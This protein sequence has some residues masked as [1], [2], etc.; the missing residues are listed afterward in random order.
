MAIGG[1][2]LLAQTFLRS[3]AEAGISASEAFRQ[4]EAGGI[5]TY[6]RTD[7]LADYREFA[8]I[9]AK[10][11]RL[12]YVRND[13]TPSRDL[14]TEVSGFQRSLY[15]YQINFDVLKRSTG[16]SFTMSTNVASETPLSKGEAQANGVN[17]IK[18][19]LDLSDMDITGYSLFGAFHK[20]G[21]LWD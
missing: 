3:A 21:E 8:N 2:K 18:D 7:M 4:M 16:E 19:I 13:Y 1:W 17:S 5:G 12:Q 10:A 14:F 11:N 9:P 6:R 15:R 20:E